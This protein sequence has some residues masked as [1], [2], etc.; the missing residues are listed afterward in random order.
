MVLSK[1]ELFFQ[2]GKSEPWKPGAAR[3]GDV[4][5]HQRGTE[6]SVLEALALSIVLLCFISYLV[7]IHP[8][9]GQLKSS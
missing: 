1:K 5:N 6:D 8:N 3:L 2:M 9:T 4:K 7:M